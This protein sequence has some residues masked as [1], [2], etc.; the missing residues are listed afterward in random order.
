[1]S[2]FNHP[3]STIY[4]TAFDMHS[5][6]DINDTI[7]TDENGFAIYTADISDVEYDIYYTFTTEDTN[8]EQSFLIHKSEYNTECTVNDRTGGNIEDLN[9][10]IHHYKVSPILK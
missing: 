8:K 7:I 3:N 6:R 10:E 5:D 4:A 2:G 1:M 9:E